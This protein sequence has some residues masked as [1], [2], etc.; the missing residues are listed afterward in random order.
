VAE[1]PLAV[2]DLDRAQELFLTS[3]TLGVMPIR[4]VDGREHP[5]GPVTQRLGELLEEFETS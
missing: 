2:S 1:Q 4:R 5:P 3:T